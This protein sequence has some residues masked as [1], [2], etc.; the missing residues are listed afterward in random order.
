MIKGFVIIAVV[1]SNWFECMEY[2]QKDKKFFKTYKE[3]VAESEWIGQDIYDRLVKIGIP[4]TLKV[5][6]EETKK[7][8]V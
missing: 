4:F 7:W 1:C 3:C 8:Q 6:C 2:E 5:Y